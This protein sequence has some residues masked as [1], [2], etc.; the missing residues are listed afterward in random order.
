MA[1]MLSLEAST[2]RGSI[3][4]RTYL[5]NQYHQI[6]VR[7]RTAP[8]NP[9]TSLQTVIRSS[10]AAASTAWKDTDEANRIAWQ[11]YADS[12]V[13]QGPL[14]PY[15]VPGRSVFL[16]NI[17]FAYN[18]NY[19]TE[20]PPSVS[21]VAPTIPG[22]ASLSHIHITPLT[23]VGIGFEVN[24]HNAEAEDMV[25]ALWRSRAFGET[26]RRFKGPFLGH[27][28][29]HGLVAPD[30]DGVVAFSELTD[31]LVYFVFLRAVVGPGNHRITIDYYIRAIA[32]ETAI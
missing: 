18:L 2:I 22:F 9:N 32:E 12:L 31:G 13:Y 11:D 29:K 28:L 4:G 27:S 10:F 8:V 5:A 3:G 30:T 20:Y 1:R 25:V 24:Y 21:L 7:Q 23:A 17:S 14:G 19:R 6:V 15:S 16:S 26:R